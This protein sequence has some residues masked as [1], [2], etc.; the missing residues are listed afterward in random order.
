MSAHGHHRVVAGILLRDRRA[1]LCHRRDERFGS[2]L[3]D[4]LREQ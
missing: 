2:L 1:L 3:R 4:A